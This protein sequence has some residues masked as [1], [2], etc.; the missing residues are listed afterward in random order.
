MQA[1]HIHRYYTC[2]QRLT[3]MHTCEERQTRD[4]T[5][6]PP[7]VER[8][9]PLIGYTTATDTNLAHSVV[10]CAVLFWVVMLCWLVVVRKRRMRRAAR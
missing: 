1:T 3:H 9:V 6:E 2:T 7:F 4:E 5:N 10:C 8:P